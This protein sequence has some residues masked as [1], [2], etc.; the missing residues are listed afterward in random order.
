MAEAPLS[1]A[2]N[3][4]PVAEVDDLR[5]VFGA[6]GGTAAAVRGVSFTLL[7]GETVGLVGESG[8]GKSATAL[9]M[10]ALCHGRAL[11]SRPADSL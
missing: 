6:R 1:S 3:G 8:S 5:V 9:S 11:M 2:A 7:E 4:R 10:L